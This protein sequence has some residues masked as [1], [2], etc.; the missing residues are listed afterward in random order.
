MNK[1]INPHPTPQTPNPAFRPR[2]IYYND[3]HHFHAKRLEPPTNIRKLRWPVDEVL[4]TGV[5]LL[6]LGL[7]YGDVYFHDSKVGRV[8]G[9]AKEVWE[10]YIDWRIMRMVQEARKLGTDQLREVIKRGRETGLTVFPSL[11]LQNEA[12][13]GLLVTAGDQRCGWLKLK[14]GADVCLREPDE[15]QAN[16]EWGYDFTLDVVREN[17]LAIIKEVLSDYEAD[18]L[19]LDFIFGGPFFRRAETEQNV[20][21]MNRFVAQIRELAND[22][23]EQQGR[24]IPISARV[25]FT[26]EENLDKGLDVETWLKEG[27]IDL[28]VGQVSGELFETGLDASWLAGAANAA[29]VPAYVRPPRGVYD[30][31][32]AFPLIEMFRAL[33]QSLSWQGIAGMYLGYLPWPFSK[34]EYQILREVAHPEAYVRRDKRYILQPRE[35]EGD[36]GCP[37]TRQLPVQLEEGKTAAIKIL[38]ADDMESARQ[39]GEMRSP[40]LTIRFSFFCIED[41]VEIRFNGRILPREDAE[42]TD[43]RDLIIP[44]TLQG[45]IGAPLDM[46]A[47][48]FRFK[49]DPD[50]LVRGENTLEVEPKRFEKTAAFVR[51]V[52]GVEIQTRYK[53]FVRPEG[54]E[55]DRVAAS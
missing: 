48:W 47:H 54:L 6:V 4:G 27:S 51:S 21:L 38:V 20:P 14:H 37:A 36:E 7:G 26:R 32:T 50:L 28:V 35:R 5:D 40:I 53:D 25:H 52:N 1:P 22:I 41:D 15:R 8:V 13:P 39:D 16:A 34:T 24:E 46:S 55:V 42:I 3:A 43:E 31:R 33:G 12:V 19:E 44:V 2:L 10:Q 23:G 45:E 30:E 29:K 11:K 49:L 17:K 18:G 9:Q